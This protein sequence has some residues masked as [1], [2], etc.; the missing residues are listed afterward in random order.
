MIWRFRSHIG[1]V[2]GLRV[3]FKEIWI[4]EGNTRGAN[5]AAQRGPAAHEPLSPAMEKG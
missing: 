5:P 1:A 2:D 3:R 4:T